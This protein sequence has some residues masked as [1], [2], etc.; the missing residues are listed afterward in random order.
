MAMGS[1]DPRCH[2][3]PMAEINVIPLVDV[4]LVL[5]VIFIITVPLFTHSAKIDLPKASSTPNI[6]QPGR[7]EGRAAAHRIG[8]RPEAA[9]TGSLG[10]SESRGTLL[11]LARLG[12][13]RIRARALLMKRIHRQ[14]AQR[15]KLGRRTRGRAGQPIHPDQRGENQHDDD[16]RPSWKAPRRLGGT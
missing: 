5:L 8:D 9:L 4:M 12:R 6:T 3:G 16:Q 11:L 2:Q 15:R 1:L 7:G 14:F 10:Q 13:G